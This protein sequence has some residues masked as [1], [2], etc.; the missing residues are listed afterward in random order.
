MYALFPQSPSLPEDALR[1]PTEL[2]RSGARPPEPETLE[3]DP[4]DLPISEEI[5]QIQNNAFFRLRS[6]KQQG[7]FLEKLANFSARIEREIVVADGPAPE[8]LFE[9]SGVL[10]DGT[11]LPTLRL[12]DDEFLH[13][14]RWVI[15][16]WGSASIISAGHGVADHLLCAIQQAIWDRQILPLQRST[17][18]HEVN[19]RPLYV[20]SAG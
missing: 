18:L 8:R 3:Q 19:V 9:V 2:D 11:P 10:H 15:K 13:A 12:K 17:P 6:N 7:K 20:H 1:L 5:Y 14:Q 4:F 16:H